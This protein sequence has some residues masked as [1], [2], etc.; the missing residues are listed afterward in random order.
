MPCGVQL[1]MNYLPSHRNNHIF[2][3]FGMPLKMDDIRISFIF[4]FIQIDIN[5]KYK[6]HMQVQIIL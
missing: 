4:I 2:I 5:H 1:P 3:Y 6:L